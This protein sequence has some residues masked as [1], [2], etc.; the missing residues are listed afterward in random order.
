MIF[1]SSAFNRFLGAIGQQYDW[2]QSFACPC[3]DPHSGAA[4]PSCPLCSG[5]GRQ[6]LDGVEG[7]AGMAGAKVQREWTQFGAYESGDVVITVGSD[8][9]LAAIG[10]FDRVTALNAFMRFSLVLTH[11]SPT[12]RLR[13]SVTKIDRVFWLNDGETSTV[14]GGIPSVSANGSLSWSDGGEPTTGAQYTIS[15][16]KNIDYFCYG[17]YPANRNEQSGLPLPRRVVLRDFD[18][19]SR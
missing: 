7:V 4:K 6:W 1:S 13:F 3:C 17:D 2:R 10:Q 8:Q 16:W 9:P 5:K 15:G 14:P 18:L 19:F 11:G 12:E